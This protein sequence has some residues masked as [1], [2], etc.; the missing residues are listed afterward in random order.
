MQKQHPI[1]RFIK[2]LY[3]CFPWY[4]WL[5]GIPLFA[6]VSS[7]TGGMETLPFAVHYLSFVFFIRIGTI[8]HET[9]HL[10]FAKLAGG[11][12]WRMHLGHGPVVD[13]FRIAK[14]SILISRTLS[15]GLAYATFDK[16]NA[17]RWRYF[18][19]VL[20][21]PA[22]NIIMAIAGWF[23]F[24]LSLH[25]YGQD[26]TDGVGS[27]WIAANVLLVCFSLVPIKYKEM[28]QAQFS[29]GM[30]LVKLIFKKEEVLK[31]YEDTIDLLTAMDLYE[32]EKF[33]EALAL[34]TKG[35][36][37]F[38]DEYYSATTLSGIFIKCGR[39]DEA[40]AE[41]LPV[42]EAIDPENMKP[43]DAM[44]LNNY[45]WCSIFLGD[46]ELA[47]ELSRQAYALD[48][49]TYFI[50]GTRGATLA[51]VGE[52]E[53]A[54]RFLAD[55]IDLKYPNS[56]SILAGAYFAYCEFMLGDLKTY[57]KYM[58]HVDKHADLLG[59]DEHLLYTQLKTRILE[60]EQAQAEG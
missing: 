19:F 12:P 22:T 42:Y 7:L 32:D 14:I 43:L 34:F 27:G 21:G 57:K 18:F 60:A 56:A 40:K 11:R 10:V 25:D 58:K 23:L 20:G 55:N 24:G 50:Q 51:E 54:K 28:G 46:L 49:E 5:L 15:G 30:F 37:Q 36:N 52:Y 38:A 31:D 47:A 45:A 53:K 33:E 41:L 16:V 29:D 48:K 4:V 26:L 17:T 44:I 39:F 2:L 59:A 13:K 6:V 35:E 3:L 9:G 1:K 8:L